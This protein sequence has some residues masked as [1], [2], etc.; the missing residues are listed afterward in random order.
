[1]L[2][3]ESGAEIAIVN[4]PDHFIVGGS[5]ESLNFLETLALKRGA[6]TVRRLQVNIPSHTSVLA[7]ASKGFYSLLQAS[8]LSNP[9]VP[10]LAGISGAV[11]RRREE[12]IATLGQQISQSLN[13]A[14]CMATAWEMGCRV[15]LELGPGTALSKMVQDAYPEAQSRSVDEFRSLKGVTNWVLKHCE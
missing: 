5:D 1:V 13:W 9:P 8:T 6:Q 14:A 7:E 15:F 2:C 10:V 4:G 3:F 11:V 12:A